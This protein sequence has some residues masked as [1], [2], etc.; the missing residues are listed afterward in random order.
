MKM[1]AFVDQKTTVDA[2]RTETT[3]ASA[4]YE[5]QRMRERRKNKRK[6]HTIKCA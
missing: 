6:F 4:L 5:W 2:W 1:Y 3:I